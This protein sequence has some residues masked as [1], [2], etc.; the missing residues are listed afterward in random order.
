MFLLI[1]CYMLEV[2]TDILCS[3]DSTSVV[4]CCRPSDFLVVSGHPMEKSWPMCLSPPRGTGASCA[5]FTVSAR[6]TDTHSVPTRKQN[7]GHGC[8]STHMITA[9]P[10][11]GSVCVLLLSCLYL[12]CLCPVLL[13]IVCPSPDGVL[14]CMCLFSC[15]AFCLLFCLVCVLSLS[16]VSPAAPVLSKS[17]EV[18][19][20]CDA[21]GGS[22][23][24]SH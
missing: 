20:C 17:H 24:H 12:C 14:S 13:C 16:S 9:T 11:R 8:H 15:P 19:F 5:G 23:L 4:T 22:A 10:R 1:D 2:D 18:L 7:T 21:R 3:C 6:R